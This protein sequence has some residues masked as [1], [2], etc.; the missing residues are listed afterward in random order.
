LKTHQLQAIN[1]VTGKVV[2]T[3]TIGVHHWSSPIMVNGIVY[4]TD[5]NSGGFGSGTTGDLIAWSLG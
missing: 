1:P 4:L 2:W 5:G 3:S